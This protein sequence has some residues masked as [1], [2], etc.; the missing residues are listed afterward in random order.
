M[1]LATCLAVAV[2]VTLIPVAALADS[3]TT[4]DNSDGTFTS[5][6]LAGTLSLAGSALSGVSNLMTPYNCPPGCSGVVS[7][8]TGTLMSGSFDPP[9]PCPT[10]CTPAIFAAGGSFDVTSHGAGGGFTFTGSFSSESWQKFGSGTTVFW[11]FIGQITNGTLTLGNGEVFNNIDAGTFDLTTVGGQPKT[12][13]GGLQWTDS[14]GSTN[15]P[16]PVPEPSTLALFGSGLI[17]VGLLA[18]RRLA[19]KVSAS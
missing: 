18:K 2:L 1:K 8:T 19:G 14:K 3:N 13:K 16:S 9:G 11:T 15:F 10:G 4:F 17:A 7:L 6:T 12:V 5:N